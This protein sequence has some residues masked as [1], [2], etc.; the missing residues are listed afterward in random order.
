MS[1]CPKCQ[2]LI[3]SEKISFKDECPS[4]RIDLHV[5]IYCQFYDEG[6]ANHCREP[7]ADYVKGR[8]RANFCEYFRFHDARSDTTSDKEAA[9]KLWNQLFKKDS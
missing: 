6:K 1:K 3:D 5:C 7:Q 4:C 2:A 8:D 9:E